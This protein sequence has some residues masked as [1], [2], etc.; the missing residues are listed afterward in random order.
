MKKIKKFSMILLALMMLVLVASC[1]NVYYSAVSGRVTDSTGT[2]IKDVNV[3]A[4]TSKS[5][6]D[7]ALAS[8]K[9]GEEFNDPECLFRATTAANGDFSIGKI[10]WKTSSSQWGNDY[11]SATIH[12][13]FFSKDYGI[14]TYDD[15]NIISGSA[16]GSSVT[17][18]M[19]SSQRTTGTLTINFKDSSSSVKKN[20]T[21]PISFTYSYNDGYSTVTQD[22]VTSTGSFAIP[23]LFKDSTDVTISNIKNAN[24]YWS[25]KDS[26]VKVTVNSANVV[27]DIDLDRE[28]Y[29]LSTGIS[30]S[31]GYKYND[32]YEV[33][34][35]G[36]TVTAYYDSTKD[37]VYGTPN[38]KGELIG[39]KGQQESGTVSSTDNPSTDSSISKSITGTFSSLLSGLEIPKEGNRNFLVVL[40]VP[41][42]KAAS[43][44]EEA[45][46]QKYVVKT[47]TVTMNEDGTILPVSIQ[48]TSDDIA[49]ALNK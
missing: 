26:E 2:G 36:S 14:V 19:G 12:F 24:G 27:K 21:D 48:I 34:L 29:A 40:K 49:S 9:E 39:F 47:A 11:A 25:C 18:N 15:V 32:N 5:E 33:Y 13:I 42:S 30:G 28:M 17:I 8:Y 4:Y 1:D 23:M 38:E 45:T 37:Y 46:A 7:A 16:N 41:V 6:R 3:Y 44:L 31:V 10:I 35:N 22:V 43:V 20:V